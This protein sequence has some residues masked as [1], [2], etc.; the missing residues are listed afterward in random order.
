MGYL[1]V[2]QLLLGNALV[3]GGSCPRAVVSRRV[4]LDATNARSRTLV[5]PPRTVRNTKLR[6]DSRYEI[7]L[8]VRRF[9]LNNTRRAV[10]TPA[11]SSVPATPM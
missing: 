9:Q 5:A 6:S 10:T 7:C 1:S 8:L 2:L 4:S 11:P 3:K